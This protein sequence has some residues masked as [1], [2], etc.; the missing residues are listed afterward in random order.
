MTVI[1]L[2][3]HHKKDLFCL[4]PSLLLIPLVMWAGPHCFYL[5]SSHAL[6]YPGIGKITKPDFVL[7]KDF[8]VGDEYYFGHY[9]KVEKM[10]EN[11]SQRSDQMLF[12]YNLVK[13]RKG[14]LPDHLLKY[15]PNQLG[16][17]YAIGPETPRLVIINMNELYWALGDMTLTERAAMMTN[18]FSPRNRNVRMIKR[19][20]ECNLVS[21]DTL[22]ANKYLHILEK[23]WVYAD[24]AKHIANGDFKFSHYIFDKRK[25]AN[26]ADTIRLSDNLHMVMMELLDTN[27]DN[28]AALDYILC[29]T[30]LLKDM[31]N[32]K[33][34]Y[35]RYCTATNRPRKKK[36]YQQALMI[37]LA[38]TK[39]P[40]EEWNKYIYDPTELQR[41]QEYSSHRGDPR[42]SDTYWYYF[43]TAKIPQP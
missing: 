31:D 30:L 19:L 37:Y 20:A 16:T 35:D 26:Q 2:L 13:A 14:E 10:V 6:S 28:T 39:A 4:I 24:W 22:A 25:F 42:F 32:F 12:F 3:C 43:D 41:F 21:N 34:D 33:R 17:F 38:G 1:G 11:A 9:D 7:E 8:A 18:V 29:S 27:P 23:T 5:T 36:L 15:I 40:Q